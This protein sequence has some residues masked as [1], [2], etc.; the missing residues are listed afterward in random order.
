MHRLDRAKAW[1]PLAL[2]GA[3]L[4]AYGVFIPWF[5]LYGDDWLYLH[6]YH[7]A[8]AWSFH[9]FV[10]ADRPFSGWVYWLVSPLFGEN[11]APYH[12]FLLILRWASGVLFWL[13]LKRLFPA[14]ERQMGWA[15]LLFVVF[16]GFVQQPIA[17]QYILH[18]TILNLFLF[19]L[20]SMLMAA[21]AWQAG[22]RRAFAW[23]YG[24]SL[25]TA[26]GL[27]S[28]EYFAGLEL[29]RPVL[30]WRVLRGQL[31]GRNLWRRI[32]AQWAPF[33]AVIAAFAFWR[34]FIFKFPTYQPQLLN[35]FQESPLRGIVWL[36]KRALTNLLTV[37]AESWRQMLVLPGEDGSLLLFLALVLAGAA[38]SAFAMLRVDSEASADDRNQRWAVEAGLL[39]VFSMLV[40]GAPIWFAGVPLEIAF[41]WDRSM[42]PFMP[43]ACLL[44]VVLIHLII[45]R[46]FHTVL[47]ALIFGLS[48]GV[49]YRNAL[50]YRGEQQALNDYFWQLTWRAPQLKSGTIIASDAIPLFRFSDN[51]LTPLLN[52]TYAPDLRQYQQE[53]KYFDL[54]LRLGSQIERAEK[55]LP[56]QHSYRGYGFTGSTDDVLVVHN[57]PG[58]CLHV[59][60]PDED[61]PGLPETVVQTRVLSNPGVIDLS[62][63][64]APP[65]VLGNE[66]EHGWCYLYERAA[67]AVQFGD[68]E[69]A[70]ELATQAGEL[71]TD[72]RDP[73]ELLPF[74]EGFAHSGDMENASAWSQVVADD[75]RFA[76]NLCQTWERIGAQPEL[77]ADAQVMLTNFGCR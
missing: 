59:L 37:N 38:F 31:P 15:A 72:G 39:G 61:Y 69:Q 2:F 56:V 18:F 57:Q 36:A 77:S 17:V 43:G 19:S 76:R 27:F 6:N 68:W 12:V 74:V 21:Q 33:L 62:G 1:T 26:F 7:S 22:R 3:V 9:K 73:F 50:V 16:P 66:P 49:Q 32:A 8:G 48:I 30:L 46:R 34:V 58:G 14:Q 55:G 65:V 60:R 75:G 11:A 71:G 64:A 24:L 40:G 5:G 53:Y 29:L 42:L 10:A 28:M 63:Q 4:L 54:S 51:D 52:W 35:A 67:L 25:L 44:L 47:L 70:G 41:P 45:Q 20:L 23:L 13:V